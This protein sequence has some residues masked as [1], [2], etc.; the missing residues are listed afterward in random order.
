MT[1]S[2]GKHKTTK[3]LAKKYKLSEKII[4]ERQREGIQI[5]RG[6]QN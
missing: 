3:K 1:K 5:A 4:Q 6:Q 2:L